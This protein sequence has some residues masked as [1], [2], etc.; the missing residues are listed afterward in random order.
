MGVLMVG[1]FSKQHLVYWLGGGE[2][3]YCI[4]GSKQVGLV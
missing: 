2:K 3:Y 4:G 1:F